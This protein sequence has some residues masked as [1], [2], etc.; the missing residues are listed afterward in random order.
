MDGSDFRIHGD[1][2]DR[3]TKAIAALK[4]HKNKNGDYVY[5]DARVL[6]KQVE[7]DLERQYYDNSDG[8]MKGL[9]AGTPNNLNAILSTNLVSR[10]SI[11]KT[12]RKSAADASTTGNVVEPEIKTNTDAQEEANLINMFCLAAIGTKKGVAAGVSKVVGTDITNS[13]LRTTDGQD[14]NKK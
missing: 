1:T 8:G 9:L 10:A 14:F 3:V 12:S 5:N 7:R 2:C 13:T 4:L 6:E 11:L